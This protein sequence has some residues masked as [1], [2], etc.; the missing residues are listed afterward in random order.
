LRQGVEVGIVTL[1]ELEVALDNA[2]PSSRA[3]WERISRDSSI[4]ATALFAVEDATGSATLRFA[5]SGTLVVVGSCYYILTAAHVWKEGFAS[6]RKLGLA[7]RPDGDDHTYMIE[8]SFISAHGPESPSNWDEW[9][10]DIVF[11]HIPEIDARR[12]EAFRVFYRLP[13]ERGIEVDENRREA[14]LVV[15]CPASFGEYT[16]THA[17][18]EMT[19]LWTSLPEEKRQGLL[20]YF[21]VRPRWPRPVTDAVSFRGLSGAGLWKVQ[22]YGDQFGYVDS[23]PILSGLAFYQMSGTTAVGAIRCHSRNTVLE[24]AATLPSYHL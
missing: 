2:N 12:I 11:L 15:G 9:G 6:A 8:K 1:D 19:T 5:G 22:V 20:D 14:Y 23:K 3:I 18:L 17:S 4:H 7:L 13:E 21:D 24:V 16:R 10:P